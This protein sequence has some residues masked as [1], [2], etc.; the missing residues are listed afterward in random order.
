MHRT[1]LLN[2]LERYSASPLITVEEQPMLERIVDFVRSTADC[3]KREHLA[4]HI[5]ASTLIVN[6]NNNAVILMHH[7]K[8]G[9]W[10]QPGGHADGD[11]NVLGVAF[12]EALEETGIE[13]LFP[14]S[15]EIFDVDVHWIPQGKAPA[16]WHYDIRF[17]FQA[18]AEAVIISNDESLEVVWVS[19]G[20]VLSKTKQRSVLRLIE[21]WQ[22]ESQ[23]G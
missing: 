9:M 5:T 20:E 16:H 2:L 12:K 7:K 8:L 14:L 11:S 13:V 4:G 23:E 1:P 22:R 10:L 6:E 3:F 18:S 19:V 21:K 15:Q 17:I